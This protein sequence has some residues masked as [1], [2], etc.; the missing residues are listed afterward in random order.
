MRE[1]TPQLVY[2]FTC[3]IACGPQFDTGTGPYGGRQYYE[4]TGATFAGSRL[5][6]KLAGSGGDW[7]LTGPDGYMRM[8][9]RMQ[10]ETQDGAVICAHYFG[11]AEANDK[12]KQA[13]LA[14]APTEFDDQS[15]RSHWVLETGDPRYAWVNQSVLAGQG[16][17]L[18][19]SPGVLGFEHKVYRLA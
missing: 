15:I 1:Q 2:E 10:I 11:P 14:C 17:L 5:M 3:R 13:V 19:A 9:V 4:I 6:G 18:P 8:D 16:R 12:L 7:M